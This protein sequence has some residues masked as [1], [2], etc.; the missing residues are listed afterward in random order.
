MNT[1]EGIPLKS[2]VSFFPK[3]F[4]V[5]LALMLAGF[6][7]DAGA[8]EAPET[9]TVYDGVLPLWS[10]PSLK[11]EVIAV[12]P[13]NTMVEE[14]GEKG[15]FLE[16]ALGD[17]NTG[18]MEAKYIDSFLDPETSTEMGQIVGGELLLLSAPAPD[19]PVTA[20]YE[21]GAEMVI[22]GQEGDYNRVVMVA[23]G[24]TGYMVD[25][26]VYV[27]TNDLTVVGKVGR[28]VGGAQ[29]LRE[30]PAANAASMGVYD[31]GTLMFLTGEGDGFYH[32]ITPDEK[33]GYIVADAIFVY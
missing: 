15:D 3:L 1:K 12:Y 13:V 4:A 32:V 28:I 21:T 2:T 8:A 29:T 33:I 20:T 10:K 24:N 5:L 18:Y 17:G 6:P 30:Q 19:A 11:S 23:D 22:E 31:S 26:Y 14:L 27:D 25:T 9:V 7:F 16:V